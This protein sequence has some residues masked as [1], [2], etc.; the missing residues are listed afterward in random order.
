VSKFIIPPKPDAKVKSTIGFVTL[1]AFALAATATLEPA[2]RIITQQKAVHAQMRVLPRAV[3]YNVQ[4]VRASNYQIHHQLHV[5]PFNQIKNKTSSA[6]RV[7]SVKISPSHSG[8]I[9]HTTGVL[10]C[11]FCFFVL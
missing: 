1:S 8:N 9:M 5:R 4:C 7:R 6:P 10:S 2:N 3:W 11:F